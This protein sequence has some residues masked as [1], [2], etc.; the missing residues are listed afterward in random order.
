MGVRRTG[1]KRKR[2]QIQKY[3]ATQDA[4]G[5]LDRTF[6]NT[7]LTEWWAE[8]QPL[9]GLEKDQ[10]DQQKAL[11]KYRIYMRFFDPGVEPDDRVRYDGRTFNITA[12]VN[13]GERDRD[14]IIDVTEVVTVE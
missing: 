3:L 11:H 9:N 4:F 10:A 13:A 1:L 7:S 2:I 5:G 8:V 6:E 14:T 12:V